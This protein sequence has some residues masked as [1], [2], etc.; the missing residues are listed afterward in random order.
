MRHVSPVKKLRWKL[1]LS[2]RAFAS[3]YGI[4]LGTLRDWE[5]GRSPGPTGGLESYLKVIAGDPTVEKHI[6]K[7]RELT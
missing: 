2:Q 6:K 4:P 3:R 7:V 1:G 5:Q